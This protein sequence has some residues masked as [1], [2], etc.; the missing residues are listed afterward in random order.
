MRTLVL[1][2]LFGRLID[3]PTVTLTLDLAL[4]DRLLNLLSEPPRLGTLLLPNPN[5]PELILLPHKVI[6]LFE[7][8]T[9]LPDPGPGL[10]QYRHSLLLEGVGFG[11][12]ADFVEGAGVLAQVECLVGDV[13]NEQWRTER[14]F[15]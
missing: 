8:I 12:A 15:L 7:V 6:Q 4:E 14:I 9:K 11:E 5:G 3:R 1:T 10:L 13:L 2:N